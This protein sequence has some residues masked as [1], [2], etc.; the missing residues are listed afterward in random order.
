LFNHLM[1][2]RPPLVDTD[3]AGLLA[4]RMLDQAR[5]S[6]DRLMRV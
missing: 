6:H 2:M 1:R 3:T 5:A 4:D